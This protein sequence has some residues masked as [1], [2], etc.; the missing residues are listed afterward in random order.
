MRDRFSY[1]EGILNRIKHYS[2][3]IL[4]RTREEKLNKLINN[5]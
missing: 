3:L 4:Q 2:S 1:S 5:K